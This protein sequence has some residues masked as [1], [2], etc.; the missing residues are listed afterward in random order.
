MP[1]ANGQ[2]TANEQTTTPSTTKTD[3]KNLKLF[4]EFMQLV[5][6]FL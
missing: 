6:K 2:M 5:L 1:K 3:D 4:T